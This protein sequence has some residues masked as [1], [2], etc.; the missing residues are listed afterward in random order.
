MVLHSNCGAIY[1]I[2]VYNK[3]NTEM[4]LILRMLLLY[5]RYPK[6]LYIIRIKYKQ[7]KNYID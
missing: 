3:K 5:I 4:N 6:I 7:T 1:K 2:K